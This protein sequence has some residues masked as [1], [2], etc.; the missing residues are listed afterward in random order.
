[1]RPWGDGRVSGREVAAT[2]V[3]LVLRGGDDEFNR[4]IAQREVLDR[5]G[6]VASMDGVAGVAAVRADANLLSGNDREA[7]RILIPVTAFV[8]H[9]EIGEVERHRPEHQPL[10]HL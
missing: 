7:D 10:C 6:A 4:L 2:T 1:M 8:N 9:P 5:L 3:A